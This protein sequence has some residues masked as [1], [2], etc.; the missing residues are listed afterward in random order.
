MLWECYTSKQSLLIVVLIL[1]HDVM[2]IFLSVIKHDMTLRA[3][4]RE[5][6][7]L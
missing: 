1:M 5:Q 6:E 2:N 4:S 3:R 7:V